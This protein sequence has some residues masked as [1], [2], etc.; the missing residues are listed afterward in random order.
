MTKTEIEYFTQTSY[1]L[2]LTTDADLR[3]NLPGAT[4]AWNHYSH[5][6]EFFHNIYPKDFY[7]RFPHEDYKLF[8]NGLKRRALKHG[9]T[10]RTFP[11][12]FIIKDGRRLSKIQ[13]MKA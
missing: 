7:V 12:D 10:L 8:Y 1:I 4:L 3:R 2:D 6:I 5:T 13:V 9:W 11:H